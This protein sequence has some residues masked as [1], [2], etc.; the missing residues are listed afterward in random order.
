MSYELRAVIAESALLASVTRGMDA[1]RVVVLRQGL[2]LLPMSAALSKAVTDAA[3]ARRADFWNLPAGFD[4][5]LADWS[6]EGPVAYVESEY[7]GGVGEEN[8]AVWRD[9][10][11]TLGP[12][13]LLE[14][15][16]MPP[17][18]TPVCRALRAL[19]A[20]AGAGGDE[21]TSVG[22]GEHRWTEKWPT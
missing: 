5:V 6:E 3:Q 1:A 12:L 2:A 16:L 11:L 22:L 4:R 14:D 15:E 10:H 19:G 17:E 18:G 20:V 21:F 13:H 9:G 7:F 8:V